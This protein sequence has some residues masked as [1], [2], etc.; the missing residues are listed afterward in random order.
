MEK[1]RDPNAH[2]RELKQ[3][4]KHLIVGISGELRTRIMKYRGK[5]E[6]V[7]DY[8][9]VVEA[10]T[11]SL[12][13]NASNTTYAQAIVARSPVRVGDEVEIRISSTDPMGEELEYSIARI[14]QKDWRKEN[15]RTITFH[16]EDIGKICDINVMVRSSRPYHAYRDFDDFLM[17]RYVVLPSL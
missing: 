1:L 2:R 4:Q 3:Y 17:Y 9:P 7:D 16:E 15:W 6:E 14:G 12:G 11:D 13:N 10:V 8:F 5:R